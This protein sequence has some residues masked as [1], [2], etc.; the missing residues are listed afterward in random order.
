MGSTE[1]D[2]L[3]QDIMVV[4]V[5]EIP[6]FRHSGHRGAFRSWLRTVATNRLRNHWRARRGSPSS[7]EDGRLEEIEDRVDVLGELVEAEHHQLVAR[8]LLELME[9]EFTPGTWLAFRRQ[10]LEGKSAA[11]AAAELGVTA[12]AVLIAKS[13]VLRRL[14]QE[15]QD[16]LG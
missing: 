16:L 10:V 7:D 4:L 6:T 5:R 1:C 8:R 2:D 12:N 3:T 13:R 14:R 9:P 11:E 15:G